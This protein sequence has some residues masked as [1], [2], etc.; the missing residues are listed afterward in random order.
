MDDR[1][2]PIMVSLALAKDEV[3]VPLGL[4]LFVPEAWAVDAARCAEAGIP[5]EHQQALAKTDIALMEIDRVI[6]AGARFGRVGA[7]AGYGV[8]AAFRFG[9]SRRGLIWAV[10]IPRVQNVYATAVDEVPP[11]STG[12]RH[13]P[14]DLGVVLGMCLCPKRSRALR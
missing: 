1:L 8:S 4:R 14:K 11:V 9:L 3:P 2:L 5:E 6:D 13:Q 10:G 12:H 7:D